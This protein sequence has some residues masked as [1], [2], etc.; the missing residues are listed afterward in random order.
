MWQRFTQSAR[1]S[2]LGAQILAGQSKSANVG[3]VHLFLAVLQSVEP[4]SNL[5]ALLLRAS[6]SLEEAK[7]YAHSALEPDADFKPHD[8]PRLNRGAKRVIELSADEARRAGDSYIGT[9]HLLLACVRLQREA[10]LS[11]VLAPLGWNLETLRALRREEQSNASPRS[12]EHPLQMLSGEAERAVEGAYGAMRATFCGRISSAHLLIGLLNGDN[13]ATQLLREIGALP[14]ELQAQARAA[15]RSDALLATPDKRFDKGAKRALDRAKFEAQSRRYKFIGADHLLLGLFPRRATLRERLTW[16]SVVK[17]E[18]ARVLSSVDEA[19]LRE[20][21]GP[22]RPKPA[23]VQKSPARAAQQ[24]TS[25]STFISMCILGVRLSATL[26]HSR[27]PPRVDDQI[28]ALLFLLLLI[29][30]GLGTC[31]MLMA[32][33]KPHLKSTWACAFFG[34]LLGALVNV[35]LLF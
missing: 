25:A 14:D 21:T 27:N 17:D 15:I 31:W 18:A 5:A 8:E 4:D 9:E 24:M 13:R 2:I 19:K 23:P 7:L 10:E 20:L 32:S 6:L 12:P 16:G 1:E 35:L 3:P 26:T 33:R 28:S 22:E 30:S 11:G 29:G 34:F